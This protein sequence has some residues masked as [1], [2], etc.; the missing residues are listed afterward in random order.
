MVVLVLMNTGAVLGTILG[1]TLGKYLPWDMAWRFRD[2]APF[3]LWSYVQPFL[4][5]TVVNI[6]TT[7]ALFFLSGALWRNSIVIYTQ[8]ILLLI[9]YQISTLF[10]TDIDL[11]HIASLIDPFGL[12]TFFATTEYWTHAEQNKMLVPFSGAILFNRALWVGL[13]ILAL[14]ITYKGF[15]FNVVRTSLLNRKLSP[16]VDQYK[17]PESVSIRFAKIA[18]NTSTYWKQLSSLTVF[19]FRLV[20]REIPFMA[21]VLSGIM[22]L[23]VDAT[24]INQIYGTS[25]YPTTNAMLSLISNSFNLFFSII[26]VFYSGELIWKERDVRFNLIMDATPMLSLIGLLSKFLSLL[27]VYSSIILVL[28]VSGVAVQV[29]HGF[30][31]FQLPIYFATLFTQTLSALAIY[32]AFYF[33]IQVVVNINFSGSRFLFSSSC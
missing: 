9:L 2:L 11:K 5:F 6:F 4:L 24:R 10:L 12:Q 22:L 3:S 15:S 33:F 18:I 19:Y 25:S 20:W 13:G 31:E 1:F 32:T 14:I 26:A 28:I 30:F 7:G 23:F 27:M 16:A 17:K 29:Y 21:I 8:G